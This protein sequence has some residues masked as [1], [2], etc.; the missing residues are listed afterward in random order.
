MKK[1]LFTLLLLLPI[2]LYAQVRFVATNNE[3]LEMKKSN[4]TRKKQHQTR[5]YL[6]SADVPDSMV[7]IGLLTVKGKDRAV[8]IDKA[9]IYGA[10][11]TGD[12]VL[13]VE[14]HDQTASQR[15]GQ[16]FI[17]GAAFKGH[18]IFIV[19]RNSHHTR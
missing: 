13:L 14:A 18:Y 2:M 16:F 11:A 9:R 4:T 3:N 8:C 5:V 19:Y 7:Q 12:A 15:V 6:N 10:R 17:G 1:I